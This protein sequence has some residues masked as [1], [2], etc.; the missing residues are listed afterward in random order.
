[1]LREHIADVRL[2]HADRDVYD[3]S[4]VRERLYELLFR[5]FLSYCS[6]LLIIL[7]P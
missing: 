3:P 6:F 1:M 4:D 2:T 7:C 5:L